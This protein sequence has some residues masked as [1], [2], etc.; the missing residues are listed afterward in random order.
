MEWGFSDEIASKLFEPFFTTKPLG[1]GSGLGLSLAYDI[2]THKHNGQIIAS[3]S[4]WKGAKFTIK[5][6]YK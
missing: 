4:D 3:E 6:C 5:L 2:I 1:L